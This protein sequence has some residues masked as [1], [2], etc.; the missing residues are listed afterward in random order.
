MHKQLIIPS[1]ILLIFIACASQKPNKNAANSLDIMFYN[2]ENLFDT[3]NDP[4][5]KDEE[6][7]PNSDKR[8][9]SEKY[10]TKLN[11]IA[12][13]ILKI[14]NNNLPDLIGVC[15]IE[16][17][18]VLL[19]LAKTLN[20]TQ[21]KISHFESPDHRG[22]DVGLFYN[23][24][25]FELI[26]EK[27]IYVQL[28][29]PKKML[30]RVSNKEAVELLKR[31]GSGA[32]RNIL[33]TNLK[34]NDDTLSVFTCH[35]PSRRG[36]KYETSYK[37]ELVAQ[38]LKEAINKEISKHPNSKIIVMGD[39]NDEPMDISM[40]KVL[41]A[42]KPEDSE[43]QLYNLFYE[44]DEDNEGSYKYRSDMNMLDQIIIS[45]NLWNKEV[46][47]KIFNPSW[48]I[49]TG[50]YAGFPLRTF[51][52]KNYLAGYSDHFPIFA[53]IPLN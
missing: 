36:G 22:I 24:S 27:P 37:R 18:S 4:R 49:Q 2:V 19:D 6:Y 16:H 33:Q 42:K 43:A 51:G 8:W 44:M 5:T 23:D 53:S 13:V 1:F 41:G 21:Y 17:K 39:F 35:F 47:P 9:N 3:I 15:E 11:H 7:L 20:T 25:I 14:D 28:K 34:L 26:S 52:G 31:N 10:Q 40:R 45:P 48:L 12:E 30:N 46:E 29:V 38:T 32:T 50:K